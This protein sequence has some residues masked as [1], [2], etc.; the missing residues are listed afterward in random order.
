MIVSNHD[1][2][3]YHWWV[4]SFCETVKKSWWKDW[5]YWVWMSVYLVSY[6]DVYIRSYAKFQIPLLDR[7]TIKLTKMTMNVSRYTIISITS[8]ACEFVSLLFSS[9]RF[10]SPK[11]DAY[12]IYFFQIKK[13]IL[14]QQQKQ[15]HQYETGKKKK[16]LIFIMCAFWYLYGVAVHMI[17]AI[18]A[19]ISEKT[20]AHTM[21]TRLKL[22]KKHQ[23]YRTKWRK[24]KKKCIRIV[25]YIRVDHVSN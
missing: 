12:Y 7:E 22:P 24:R 9:Q 5:L 4:L 1:C 6:D 2:S 18:Y 10:N 8:Y 25:S 15:R 3:N 20:Q 17:R 11:I 19:N 13:Y 16:E 14:N 23:T 21:H